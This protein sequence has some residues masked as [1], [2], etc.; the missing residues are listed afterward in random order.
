MR[1]L[2]FNIRYDNMADAPRTWDVRRADVIHTI[3]NWKPDI[4]TIEEALPHQFVDLQDAFED[5]DGFGVPRDNGI[6]EGEA[7]IV[8]FKKDQFTPLLEGHKWLSSTPDLP[9]KYPGA[10][11]IREFQW[12]KLQHNVTGQQFLV[13]ATHLDDQ[14]GAARLFGV[15]EI[16][17]FLKNNF[18]DVF[19]EELPLILTGDFNTTEND[20]AYLEMAQTLDD[21][22]LLAPIHKDEFGGTWQDNVEDPFVVHADQQVLQLDFFFVKALSVTRYI[23]ETTPINGAWPSDHFPILIDFSLRPIPKLD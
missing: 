8:F 12:V 11:S 2:Q 6:D 20:P 15:Q 5:Y 9:S 3:A 21:A 17:A 22:R 1:A 19:S 4:F 7:T 14:S 23:V 13:V 10:G 16:L 18:L